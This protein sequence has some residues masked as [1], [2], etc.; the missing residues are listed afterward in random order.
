MT[1]QVETQKDKTIVTSG[2]NNFPSGG[3]EIVID[4][5]PV[6]IPE[7]GNPYDSDGEAHDSD[8]MELLANPSKLT[9]K[10]RVEQQLPEPHVELPNYPVPSEDLASEKNLPIGG[11]IFD[12]SYSRQYNPLTTS[13]IFSDRPQSND[14][15]REEKSRC[16][17]EYNKK[18]PD[19][20][21]NARRL[22]MDDSLE[23]IKN[24]LSGVITK[25]DMEGSLG[26]WRSG[27]VFVAD[28]ASQANTQFDPFQVDMSDWAKGINYDVMVKN[29]YD[30]VLEELIN[31]YRGKMPV[32]PEVKLALLL[33]GSFGMG[34]MAKKREQVKLVEM[35]KQKE[36]NELTRMQMVEMQNKMEKMQH[37]MNKKQHHSTVPPPQRFQETFPVSIPELDL[38]PFPVQ[39]V[40]G[41]TVTAE[42]MKRALESQF[43]DETV[44]SDVDSEDIPKLA[45]VEEFAT[46]E[47]PKI[48]PAKKRG[49]PPKNSQQPQV[50]VRIP[51]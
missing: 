50:S 14:Q 17:Y 3:V 6:E 20:I 32:S 22:T 47:Q 48:L 28:M 37:E 44:I 11:G 21:Y 4:R 35:R 31:K 36:L 12:N 41:P 13:G 15:I 43:M 38:P 29:S 34:V 39:S 7:K 33:V 25:R 5:H 2:V 42:E 24:S 49:R 18:N 1:I 26:F 8:A 30:D 46:A 9:S 51:S 19:G 27:L 10:P 45:E 16:I 23:E 40:S